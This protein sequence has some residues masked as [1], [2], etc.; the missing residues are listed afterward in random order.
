MEKL[1]NMTK[2]Q[3]MVIVGLI[4][5]LLLMIL[6]SELFETN[7]AG[8]YQVKQAAYSGEL[9]VKNSPGLYSKMFGTIHTYQVSD[10][11]YFSKHK[12]DGGDGVEAAPIT[13]RFNDGGTAVISGSIKYRLSSKKE[14]Q[15]M[16][17]NDFKTYIMVKQDLV[18]QVVTEALKQSAAMMKAEESYSSRRSEFTTLVEGQIKEG[19]YETTFKESPKKDASGKEF[20]ISEVKVKYDGK[21]MPIIRKISPFKRYGVEVLQFVIKDIDFDRTIDNLI[22]KKKLAEQQK[23]VA[24]ANAEK[25]K[26]D[27]ITT[28]AQGK[29]RIAKAKADEEVVKIKAVTNAL[30]NKE[31]EILNAER[32]FKVAEFGAK[33]A[34]E[35][36]KKIVAKGKADAEANRLKV[37]AGL[38]P[39][40][41]AE[42]AY[43]T[44]VGVAKELSQVAVPTIVIGGGSSK[45]GKSFGPLDAIGVNMLLDI[46]EKLKK[47]KK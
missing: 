6:Y 17:H 39:Q 10:M 31:V 40:E 11:Y 45:D 36:A 13:V 19:I 35:E 42:W 12:E 21:K 43:K 15:L 29:A 27:A 14:L 22:S 25:A 38:S 7:N 23:V 9:T 1:L 16:L 33:Q 26:Q 30:K 2:R 41:K 46:K 47:S 24:K 37:A 44:E 20:I 34:K 4:I 3:F 5:A 18:R 32:K 28:F 8:Y